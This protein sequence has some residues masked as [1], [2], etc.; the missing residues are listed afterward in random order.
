MYAKNAK[1]K[2]RVTIFTIISTNVRI[3]TQQ[4]P[5]DAAHVLSRQ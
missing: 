3:N 5:D 2:I 1:A 4:L